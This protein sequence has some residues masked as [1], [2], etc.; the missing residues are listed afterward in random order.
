MI[1]REHTIEHNRYGYYDVV[2]PLGMWTEDTVEEAKNTL[3]D[4]YVRNKNRLEVELRNGEHD[5]YEKSMLPFLM[6]DSNVLHILDMEHD[7]LL[8]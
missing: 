8:K 2:G 5:F 6:E 4:Y 3:D 7:E 1:Y